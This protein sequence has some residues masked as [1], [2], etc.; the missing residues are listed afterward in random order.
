M[1]LP[2][3]LPPLPPVPEG[4]VR[5]ET[6][7]SNWTPDSNVTYF[8]CYDGTARWFGPY[9]GRPNLLMSVTYLEAV[10]EPAKATPK[11]CGDVCRSERPT[12]LTD[13]AEYEVR[14]GRHR[15]KVVRPE[16][17]RDLERKLAEAMDALEDLVARDDQQEPFNGLD[18][19]RARLALTRIN[20][21]ETP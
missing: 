2:Q 8:E 1:N 3:G 6:R 5:L 9:N 16:L 11:A 20:K 7:S 19:S 14:L 4:F 21:T 12:P 17:C 13:K 10:R 15:R 18:M